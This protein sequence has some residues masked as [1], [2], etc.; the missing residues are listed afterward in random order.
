M[1][2]QILSTLNDYCCLSILLQ[3]LGMFRFILSCATAI[4]VNFSFLFDSSNI[5]LTTNWRH[6]Q[7]MGG[8]CKCSKVQ[9]FYYPCKVPKHTEHKV[10]DFVTRE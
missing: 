2:M 9:K 7:S 8:L 10:Y 1:P 3:C 6:F 5:V 4:L